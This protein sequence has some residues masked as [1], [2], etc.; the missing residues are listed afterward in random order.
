MRLV[1]YLRIAMAI[2]IASDEMHLFAINS[3]YAG[4]L[5]GNTEQILDQLR[6]SVA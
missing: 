4:G 2:E 1:L 6:R 3:L 5:R